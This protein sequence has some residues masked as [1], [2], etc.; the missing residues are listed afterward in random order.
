MKLGVALPFIDVAVGG[1]PAAIREFA[2]T[3]EEIGYQDLAAPDHVLGVNVASCPDWGD[4]NTSADLFHDPFVLFGFLANC[5]RHIEFSTQALILAQRQAVLVAKQ[6]ASLDVLCGGRFRLGIGVGWNPVEFVGLNENFRNRGRRSEE[7]VEVMQALWAEPHVTFAG[8]YHTIEDAGI[9]PLPTRR[10]IPICFGGHADATME[11]VVK[12]GDGWMPLNYA[13]GGDAVAAFDKLRGMAEAAGPIR[14]A[15]AS[16][17]GPLSGSAPRPS[18][19]RPSASGNRAASILSRFRLKSRNSTLAVRPKA[20]STT[21]QTYTA[22]IPKL[23]H[24]RGT[25]TRVKTTRAK[26]WVSE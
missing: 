3:A 12:R 4:R 23:H 15:S 9:N 10:R 14:P 13:P 21:P 18:G 5:T 24:L 6:A 17:P 22:T 7:Q 8:N 2:Q 16:I 25:L 26:P 19:A 1:D 11:R 20:T